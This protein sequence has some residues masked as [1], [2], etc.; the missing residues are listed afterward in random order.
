MMANASNQILEKAALLRE[1]QQPSDLS[2]MSPLSKRLER[3]LY[4]DLAERA[5]LAYGRPRLALTT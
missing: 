5:W 2:Q 3:K 1:I 4:W